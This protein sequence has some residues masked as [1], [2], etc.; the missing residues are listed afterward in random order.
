M[1]EGERLYRRALDAGLRPDLSFVAEGSVIETVGATVS[2]AG[3]ALDKGSYRR[4]S[5]DVIGIFPQVDTRLESLSLPSDPLVLVA[6][7]IEKPGNLGA[8]LRT[9]AAAGADAV[10]AVGAN[11]DAHNPNTVRAATGALFTVPLAVSPWDDLEPWLEARD[12]RLFCASPAGTTPVWDADLTG[13][14]ALVVGAEDMGLSERAMSAADQPIFIPQAPG[15][16]DS[17]NVS[18]TAAVLLFEARRQRGGTSY[19]R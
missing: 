13:S 2:V 7:N 5:Q 4:R 14:I 10:I 8:M 15:A 18:A 17:L 11:P 16:I 9:A 6:E 3:E 19:L 1:V 12:V